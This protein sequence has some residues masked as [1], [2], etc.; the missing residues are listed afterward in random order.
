M[1]PVLDKVDLQKVDLQGYLVG[2]SSNQTLRDLVISQRGV[3]GGSSDQSE[4]G[5]GES[6]NQSEQV[7]EGEIW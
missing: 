5:G 4:V 2:G 1:M 3:G 7:R 6:G